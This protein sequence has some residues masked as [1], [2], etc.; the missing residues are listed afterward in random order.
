M[1]DD[2][3]DG[4]LRDAKP[5]RNHS[6]GFTRSAC[7][8]NH[9]D[10]SHRQSGIVILFAELKVAA[11]LRIA[12]VHVVAL[13]SGPQVVEAVAGGVVAEVE[14]LLADDPT[15]AAVDPAVDPSMDP[16]SASVEALDAIAVT[17]SVAVPL[18]TRGGWTGWWSHGDSRV[19][20]SFSLLAV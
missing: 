8:A 2:G 15:E 9:L 1:V 4:G 11:T 20:G 7:E 13:C 17:F 18:P 14:D 12:I 10:I 6:L 3:V 16:T 19:S 5:T